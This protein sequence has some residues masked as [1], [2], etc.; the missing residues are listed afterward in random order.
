LGAITWRFQSLKIRAQS[1]RNF[2]ALC[3]CG[4][5]QA[6][7]EPSRMLLGQESPCVLEHI[8]GQQPKAARIPEAMTV[9]CLPGM[10]FGRV[11]VEAR[12]S[13]QHRRPEHDVLHR[14]D[15]LEHSLSHAVHGLGRLSKRAFVWFASGPE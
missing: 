2:R 11:L 14:W 8:A 6:W 10:P 3:R 7:I 1:L 13:E 5:V 15:A 12:V 4:F 9:H